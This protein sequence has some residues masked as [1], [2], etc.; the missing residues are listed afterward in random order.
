MTKPKKKGVTPQKGSDAETK[1][2][3]PPTKKKPPATQA[4]FKGMGPIKIGAIDMAEIAWDA[5]KKLS[6]RAKEKEN[7][8]LVDLR[9]AFKKHRKKLPTR[10]N[11]QHQVETFYNLANGAN[12]L[13][14]SPQS[15]KVSVKPIPKVKD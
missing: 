4:S 15:D 11:D 10:K 14:F 8:C 13:T 2:T 1:L 7:E 5:A 6:K 9:N 12:V 3:K